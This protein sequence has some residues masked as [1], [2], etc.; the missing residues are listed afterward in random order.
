MLNKKTLLVAVALC[1]AAAAPIAGCGASACDEVTQKFAACSDSSDITDGESA[2]CN[3][4][5]ET[6]AQC[7]L[8][9][10]KDV[11]T[12][13]LEIAADCSESCSVGI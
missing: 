1:A 12:Q 7:Y 3:E 6:C 11:C 8:D 10:G 4:A 2:D 5:Q 13:L 9:S